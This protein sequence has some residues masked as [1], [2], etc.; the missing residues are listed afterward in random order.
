MDRLRTLI[1][2]SVVSVGLANAQGHPEDWPVFGGSAQRTGWEKTDFRIT[3][4][5][6]KDFQLVLKHKLD[7]KLKG[8]RALSPPVVLGL[9]ISYRGFK[10]L[11]FVAGS[12]DNFW[13]LDA[14]L[15]RVFWQ[16]HFDVS[17][18]KSKSGSCAAAVTPSLVPPANFAA[19][20]RPKPDAPQPVLH[21]LMPAHFGEP[22]PV[23]TVSSDGKLRT[24]NTANGDDLIAPMP[25]LPP[26]SKASTLTFSNG[27]IYTTTSGGCGGAPD[28][29]WAIDLNAADATTP[30]RV[31]HF[32]STTGPLPALGGL[33]IA[34]DGTVYE[35]TPGSLAALNAGDL[36]LKQSFTSPN[37]PAGKGASA[38]TP[39][40]FRYKEQELIASASSDG[41]ISLFD[42]S[43]PD[44][45]T[46]LFQTPPIGS[47]V[48]A[49]WGGLSSWMDSDGTPWV[50]APVW[51][52]VSSDI[53]TLT[54]TTAAPHG[55]IVAFRVEEH[56]GK[57]ILTPVWVSRDMPS[58]EPPVITAGTVFALSAGEYSR[59]GKPKGSSH[60]TLYALDAKTGKE[61]YSTGNQVTSPADLT[62][63]AIANAR[64]YFTTTDNTLYAFGIFLER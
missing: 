42:T 33:A 56:D 58:P 18:A 4:D 1:L 32:A 11:A 40:I 50:L 35:Q 30:G 5:N 46:P 9:L 17:G 36:K 22:R 47:R 25:F 44:M 13:S 3:K 45:Q 43:A 28:S 62:G 54:S 24:L 12:P 60:A 48:G 8:S 23:F 57:P 19:G 29:V 15:D 6:V 37:S 31:S 26:G 27:V 39:V 53:A 7:N 52:P 61:I 49:I 16:K 14:D 64:V 41:R 55:S 51:G 59:D 10:E 20:G 21:F 2:L 38:V 34:T 63:V